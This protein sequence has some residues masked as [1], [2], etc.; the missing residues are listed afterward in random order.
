MKFVTQKNIS[1]LIGWLLAFFAYIIFISSASGE[2]LSPAEILVIANSDSKSSVA[3]AQYYIKKRAIPARNLLILGLTEDET[4]IRKVY[5]QEIVGPVRKY[6]EET[7]PKYYI[8][9]L[10]LMYG[11]PLKVAPPEASDDE[12]TQ[13]KMLQDQKLSIERQLAGLGETEAE[14]RKS[15]QKD[16]RRIK[17]QAAKSQNS[18]QWAS[19]DSELAL[20]LKETY[21]LSGWQPNPFYSRNN[22][23][24]NF[25]E[26]IDTLMVGRLD[27]PD[28]ETVK[29]IIDDS[30]NAEKNG[31]KGTAYF[32]ARWPLENSKK[33]SAYT[34]YDR[35]I[36]R[37]AELVKT[38]GRLPVVLEQTDRLFQPREA[39][40]AA[41]YCG[42]YSLGQYVDAF[43]WQPGSIGFHI[44]SSECTTLKKEDSRVWCRMM[45]QKGVAATLG[46][47]GEPYLQ[48]FPLPELFFTLL[49]DGSH[50]LV[51]T[52]FLSLPYLSW[53]MVLIG[54]PLYRP[55]KK[56]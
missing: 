3:L 18:D 45:L 55:F 6:L 46:P 49:L 24:A 23:K 26:R 48:A 13:I 51:E 29:R 56:K 33:H 16:L 5:D 39:P 12:R 28:P 32:D 22:N 25:A 53:K 9:C 52:Y 4:C 42:W 10:V 21:P 34:R 19:L 47:V 36:H 20:V 11:V 27:G 17:M 15:L 1:Y 44:A 8:R 54:D 40:N 41:L 37:A 30:L 38:D 50:S 31:L 7:Y 2:V 35:S 43:A 14:R